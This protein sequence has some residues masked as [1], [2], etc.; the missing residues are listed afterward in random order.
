MTEPPLESVYSSVVSLRSL[1]IVIFLAE[2]NDLDIWGADV[3]N[4][5]LEA[6]TKEKLF[7]VAGPEFGELSG[8]ILVIHKAI[9][10]LRSSGLCYRERFADTLR[11]MGF[12][13]SRADP[14]VW[15][16]KQSGYYEYIAV[17]V[18]DLAIASKDPKAIVNSLTHDHKYKL[19]GVGPL[20]HHL[21]CD[22]E[23]D[24]DGTLRQIP[25][26]YITKI[27]DNYEKMFKEKPKEASSPLEKGDH[28]ELDD[29]ELL[30]SEGTTK[31]Q[32]LIGSLQWLITLGRFDV[33]TAVMTLSRFRAQPREGHLS[34]AK[35]VF[36]YVKKFKEGSIRIRTDIPDYS[37]LPSPVHSWDYSVCGN[38][39]EEIPT[40][41][42]EALGKPVVLTS[43]VD[44]NLYHDKITG[45]SM[46]GVIHLIN[47]TP[48]DW[49]T[50]KQ[51]TV[52]TATYGSEFSAARTAVEQIIDLRTSLRYLGVPVQGKSY[53]FGDNESVVKSS[54]VPQ[55]LL[56][57]R[58]TALSYH[59]V[60]EA[61]AAG[62]VKPILC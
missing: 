58:H 5:Y 21:G 27:L 26:K 25:R 52:E 22:F 2:L 55:S 13:S 44:A 36:G 17:Y 19:K 16:R 42:P 4:A 3:G 7:I 10:G 41:I 30:E 47:Q 28:P 20:T 54:T 59:R 31:F 33:A 34:R 56:N 40:D 38:V 35:R 37:D 32:S 12:I 1:R 14:D 23:C 39:K 15:M 45:R 51:S 8:H 6:K 11:E 60:R 24:P 9:Y 48:I 50:K 18:D 29:T 61:I 53:M 43:Y 57:K 46:T 49:Y 62:I